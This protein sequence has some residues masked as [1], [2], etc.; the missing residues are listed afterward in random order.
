M[1]EAMLNGPI[2]VT[3][4]THETNNSPGQM[5][6]ALSQAEKE[7]ETVLFDLYSQLLLVL[8]SL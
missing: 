1:E 8:L 5:Q 4:A 6:S 7:T 2:F 3:D